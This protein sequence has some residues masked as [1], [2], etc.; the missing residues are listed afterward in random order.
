M[1]TAVQP[2]TDVQIWVRGNLLEI[3]LIVSGAI[4]AARAVHWIGEVTASRIDANVQ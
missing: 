1:I 2:L 3:L 4:L